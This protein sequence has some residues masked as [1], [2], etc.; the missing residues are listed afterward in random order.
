MTSRLPSLFVTGSARR[1]ESY[2]MN[3]SCNVPDA[4]RNFDGLP[5]S[6]LAPF[7]S[8]LFLLPIKSRQTIYDWV[9]KGILPKPVKVGSLS[10]FRV[11]DLRAALK[12]L[13]GEVETE[14]QS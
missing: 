5:D 3:L 8:P 1:M 9:R 4:V 10:A 2:E 13:S 12:K 6:A 11:G 7:E 14:T